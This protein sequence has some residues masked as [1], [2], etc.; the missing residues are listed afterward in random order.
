MGS[1]TGYLHLCKPKTWLAL[2]SSGFITRGRSRR[3]FLFWFIRIR[4]IR[5]I[6]FCHLSIKFKCRAHYWVGKNFTKTTG[7]TDDLRASSHRS[8][9]L[10]QVLS[11]SS[12][13]LLSLKKA[14]LKKESFNNTNK[15]EEKSIQERR[16]SLKVKLNH[17]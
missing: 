12:A 6:L 1:R 13:P 10:L 2:K 4:R 5:F 11:L 17:G 3:R 7:P 8:Q 15:L 16:I 14:Y 9:V